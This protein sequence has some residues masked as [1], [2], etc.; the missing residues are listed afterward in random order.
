MASS[1]AAAAAPFFLLLFSSCNLFWIFLRLGKS[2]SVESLVLSP[3]SETNLADEEVDRER[4]PLFHPLWPTLY[5][6][7]RRE[8]LHTIQLLFFSLLLFR[9]DILLPL[10]FFLFF[11]LQKAKIQSHTHNTNTL[12]DSVSFCFGQCQLFIRPFPLSIP[13]GLDFYFQFLFSSG[14]MVTSS[15]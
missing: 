2:E 5:P 7:P 11:F 14:R 8:S 10:L 3:T 6:S 13:L 4:T 12:I 15:R 9:S 1:S